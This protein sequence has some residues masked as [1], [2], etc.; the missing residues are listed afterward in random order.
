MRPKLKHRLLTQNQDKMKLYVPEIGDHIRLT[1]DWTFTLHAEGRNTTLAELFGF[2]KYGWSQWL[3]R[4]KI[5]D[6]PVRDYVI[7]YPDEE[8]FKRAFWKGQVTY[9][10]R[11]AAYRK[12]E[13]DSASYQAYLLAYED[14]NN[15]AKELATD[16]LVITLPAG[17]V[18]AVDRIYIRKGASDYSSITFY[19]KGLGESAITNRWSGKTTKW[20]A[21]R[22][23]AKL[24]DCNQIEFDLMDE[25]EVMSVF[26]VTK[27]SK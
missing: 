19:A 14:W 26:K 10:E 17:T 16:E 1:K 6:E 21:Q 15:R 5:E 13:Q 25:K 2:R 7:N 11:Q 12:A 8:F 3:D 23:W 20:K 24:S 27:K 4:N 9:E 18:L 22:F